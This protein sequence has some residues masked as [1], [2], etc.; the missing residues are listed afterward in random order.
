[1]RARRTSATSRTR[2]EPDV[3][4]R[5]RPTTHA[6]C[7]QTAHVTVAGQPQTLL[8]GRAEGHRG[9]HQAPVKWAPRLAVPSP[10][11]RL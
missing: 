6:T 4:R 11:R 5:G 9:E 2:W 3:A 7:Q 10:G 1:M 8:C